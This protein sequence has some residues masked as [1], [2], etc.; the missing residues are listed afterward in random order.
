MPRILRV[1]AK[2]R[3]VDTTDPKVIQ[4]VWN[5][6]H[7]IEGRPKGVWR[8]DDDGRLIRRNKHGDRESGDGWEIDH[9]VL[10][11]KGGKTVMSNLRPLYWRTNA[12]RQD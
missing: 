4:A 6:G 11:S 10:K 7:V 8:N 5:K 3:E 9:I 1:E 12:K 2:E